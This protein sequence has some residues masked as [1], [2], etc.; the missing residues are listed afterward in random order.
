MIEAPVPSETVIE[1]RVVSKS[2]FG[3]IVA[4]RVN[5]V[6]GL[7]FVGKEPMPE[8]W[9]TEAEEGQ[10]KFQV[11]A[12]YG[13]ESYKTSFMLQHGTNGLIKST[14]SEIPE[15]AETPGLTKYGVP[16]FLNESLRHPEFLFIGQKVSI[17][18]IPYH[19]EAI[20]INVSKKLRLTNS[21]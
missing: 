4:K 9:V 10:F 8:V 18:L 21:Y 1:S 11:E 13:Q 3:I 19:T 6:L 12:R 15:Q 2:E 5:E 20:Q 16:D 7:K 14:T 17:R